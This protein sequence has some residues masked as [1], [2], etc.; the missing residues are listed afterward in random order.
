MKI[1]FRDRDSRNWFYLF[2]LITWTVCL[3][4]TW[5]PGQRFWKLP[6]VACLFGAGWRRAVISGRSRN[7][8]L[9]MLPLLP[10][11]RRRSLLFGGGRELSLGNFSSGAIGSRVLWERGKKIEK[12]TLG[13]D[14]GQLLSF[15]FLSFSGVSLQ[16]GKGLNTRPICSCVGQLSTTLRVE[17]FE[18]GAVYPTRQFWSEQ[19]RH[20]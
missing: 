7:W 18:E 1:C 19:L 8:P 4:W 11:L 6:S 13:L 17:A 3:N 10:S 12:G 5:T 16:D 20:V 14:S 15:R 9:R 2:L